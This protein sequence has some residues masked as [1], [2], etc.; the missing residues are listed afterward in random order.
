MKVSHLKQVIENMRDED[1]LFVAIFDKPE[2]DEH[3]TNNLNDE[4][5]FVFTSEQWEA[6]VESMDRD[7]GIWEEIMGSW[8]YFIEKKFNEIKK[9]NDD[10]SK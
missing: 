8:R 9:G 2:A 7:E 4:K 1:I 3:A 5:D 10:N 6:I